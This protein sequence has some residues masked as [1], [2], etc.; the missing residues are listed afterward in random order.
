MQRKMSDEETLTSLK[1]L[2]RDVLEGHD[3]GHSPCNCTEI[4]E[5][6]D[7]MAEPDSS[8]A[9]YCLTPDQQEM[10]VDGW[11][12]H[13]VLH[14]QP[15]HEFLGLTEAEYASWVAGHPRQAAWSERAWPRKT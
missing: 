8:A 9:F 1:R 7:G 10:L 11:Y 13:A 14:R 3:G 12:D 6:L 2:L 5:A 15:L 4:R